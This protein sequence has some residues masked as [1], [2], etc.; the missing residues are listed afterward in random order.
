MK[1]HAFDNQVDLLEVLQ[2]ATQ[3]TSRNKGAGPEGELVNRLLKTNSPPEKILAGLM[4]F[5]PDLYSRLMSLLQA[6]LGNSGVNDLHHKIMQMAPS[7]GK[8]G[9]LEDF[10]QEEDAHTKA[11]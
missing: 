4:R 9:R 2:D 10:I 5:D 11:T 6:N 3:K 8:G 1:N 7:Q